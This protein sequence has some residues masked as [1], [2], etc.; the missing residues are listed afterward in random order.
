[1]SAHTL[2][3]VLAALL[4][5]L[6]A[7]CP[8]RA[9]FDPGPLPHRVVGLLPLEG[10]PEP[11]GIAFHPG[12]GTLFVVDDGGILCELDTGGR[13]LRRERIRRADF[14]GVT[15]D[16]ATGLLYIAIEGEDSILEV[17]PASFRAMREF[18]LPRIVAGK[19][20]LKEGGQGIEA[21][22]I[23][24][25]GTFLVTNQGTGADDPGIVME[26][27]LPL[28]AEDAGS[29]RVVRTFDPGVLDL[30]ALLYLA[31]RDLVLVVSDSA[32]RLMAFSRAGAPLRSWTLPGRDQ[33][34]I[35]LD[36]DGN[37][38]IAQDSGGVLKIAVD[39]PRAFGSLPGTDSL[40]GGK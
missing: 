38:Y 16:P 23:T 34:G 39:W 5:A 30:S 8:G 26:L 33:E 20:L 21:V 14:E 32:N 18:P 35:A 36:A 40:N 9:G 1:M 10:V 29:V 7:G 22:T 11:S 13:V 17:D 37:L 12:R 4:S 27:E 19:T 15:V 28:R 24:P 31:D 6:Q 25:D 3:F 2:A